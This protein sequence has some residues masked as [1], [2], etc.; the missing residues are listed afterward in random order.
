VMAAS[1]GTEQDLGRGELNGWCPR[2]GPGTTRS[3]FQPPPSVA[4]DHKETPLVASSGVAEKDACQTPDS[5]AA[6][7]ETNCLLVRWKRV[8]A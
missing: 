2:R 4:L 1:D 6:R 3:V 5:N 7:S 8:V